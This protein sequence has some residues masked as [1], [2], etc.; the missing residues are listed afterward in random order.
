MDKIKTIMLIGGILVLYTGCGHFQMSEKKSIY[1]ILAQQYVAKSK[2]LW[3]RL[4]SGTIFAK[5][6]P[7]YEILAQQDAKQYVV[8]RKRLFATRKRWLLGEKFNENELYRKEYNELVE[9]YKVFE[10]ELEEFKEIEEQDPLAILFG[11][12][13]YTMTLDEMKER[14]K[15]QFSEMKKKGLIISKDEFEKIEKNYFTSHSDLTRIWGGEYL[16]G[17]INESEYLRR[18]YDVPKYVIVADDPNRIKVNI[19][20]NEMFPLLRDLEHD[21]IYFIKIVGTPSAF[22]PI[23]RADLVPIGFDDFSGPGNIILDDKTGTYYVVDTE[24]KSFKRRTVANLKDKFAYAEL[25]DELEYFRKRFLYLNN[26]ITNYIYDMDLSVK[27]K[28]R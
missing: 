22:L 7:I 2:R 24:I 19:Y 4:W 12:I 16:K 14:I 3:E 5:E 13:H 25:K 27:T 6:K 18:N 11:G 1:E 15:A 21:S 23:V 8:R 17:K 28:S 9:S 26:N 10:Y 20:F